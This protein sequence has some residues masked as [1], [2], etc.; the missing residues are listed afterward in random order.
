M[1]DIKVNVATATGEPGF[2]LKFGEDAPIASIEFTLPPRL[3][4]AL[5]H[6][7]GTVSPKLRDP[8]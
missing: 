1:T 5:M 6:R 3:A 7:I 2:R 4:L 8:A